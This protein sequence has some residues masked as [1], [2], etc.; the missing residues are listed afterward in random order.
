MNK[1]YL[2]LYL[3]YKDYLASATADNEFYDEMNT[4]INSGTNSYSLFNRYF[5]KKIDLKWVEEIE[6]CIIPLDN[7]IRVPR[8]FIVQEEEIVPIER[9]RKITNES[10]RHLAQH[11]N[12]IAKVEGDDVTPNQILNVF[13]E[14]SY[15]VY[16]N[17][18]VFTL[19]QNLV[20]FIDVRYNVLFNI[21][22]D[23]NMASLKME[24]N[25]NRGREKVQYKLEVSAQSAGSD[26][27]GEAGPEGENATA[28]QRI[29]RVKRIINEYANSSFMKE[30]RN[31]VPVRPPI[32][33]TN[34]I[35]KNPNFRACLK[36]WQ[37]IQSYN[38]LGYEI[39]V[40]ES[41]DMVSEEYMNELNRMTAMN[42]MMLKAN[43]LSEDA[44][45]KQKKRKIKPKLLKRLAE[46]LVMDYDMEEVEIQ[47]VF[48]DEV[49]RVS[50]KKIEGEKKIQEA[51]QRALDSENARK[52]AIEDKIKAKIAHEKEME[53]RRIAREKERARKEKEK[54]KQ[55][56]KRE[57]ERERARIAKEKALA[58]EKAR[59]EKERAAKLKAQE[60]ARIAKEKQREEMRI[61]REKAAKLAQIEKEKAAKAKAKERE[62]KA[63]EL[64]AQKA[65]EKAAAAKKRKKEAIAK[66]RAAQAEKERLAKE[67]AKQKE[68]A[69]KAAQAEKDRIAK[70]KAKEKAAKARAAEAEKQRV[71]KEKA[72]E[73]ERLAKEKA[74][75]KEAA[76]K[77]AQAEKDR[78]AKEK[79]KQKEAAAKAAQAEKDR[80]A[81]EK[82]KEK[83][84]AVKAAEAEKQR[85]AKE[86]AKEK[87]KAAREKAKAKEKERI[88]KMRA[89]EA[90]KQRIAKEKAK[91]KERIAREKIREQERAAK[92]KAKEKERIAREKARA[93]AKEQERLARERAKAKEAKLKADKAAKNG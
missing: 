17:R 18:F 65:K 59:K 14:E 52:K 85:I 90:E 8:K 80:I 72:K 84:A 88:A 89:A 36:L 28:F 61:A 83:A 74:K 21:S 56:L 47:R 92:E 67:K 79:A 45:G 29:E 26:V 19:M 46:E 60:E 63:K 58:K 9:A 27:E 44:V 20:R 10:I 76:A 70:E 32:M 50:R 15:E 91:E 77:A 12:M 40:K 69:A 16:E 75:Q 54:E 37:F 48:V 7:I 39:T 93:K 23:D 5:D 33:R 86:K 49:K 78:I 82:A 35:Q 43:T 4:A 1:S 25:F 31:C 2:E 53:R 22:D 13:R 42:Y 41:N 55:R 87:E 64:A 6:A 11:T 34:A 38:E 62:R 3:E 81:K 24:S 73:K 51:I 71:A 66:A 68:A 30:L 57:K